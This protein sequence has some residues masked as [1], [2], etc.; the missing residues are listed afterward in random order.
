MAT[1]LPFAL[2]MMLEFIRS[3]TGNLAVANGPGLQGTWIHLVLSVDP[4]SIRLYADGAEQTTFAP[5]LDSGW[6]RQHRKPAYPNP[7]RSVP[8][9]VKSRLQEIRRLATSKEHQGL[10]SA[11][12]TFALATLAGWRGHRFSTK[13]SV[14]TMLCVYS[15]SQTCSTLAPTPHRQVHWTNPCR[16]LQPT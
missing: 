5:K 9:W 13:Q 8:V 3:S 7:A 15:R 14:Q 10:T 2:R 12:P 4:N 16:K 11:P 1:L 6:R